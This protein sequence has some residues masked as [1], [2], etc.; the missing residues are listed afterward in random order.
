MKKIILGG[1]AGTAVMTMMMYKVAPMI[2]GK[3]MDIASKLGSM[4][5]DSWALGM[6]A[7]LLNG[8]I[9]FPLIYGLF[10]HKYLPGPNA[11]KG[12]VWGVILWLVAMLV[13]MPVVG[14]GAFM[15]NSGSPKAAM[16]ALMGH[17]VYGLIFGVVSSS[18]INIRKSA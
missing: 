11:I 17:I 9:V 4:L 2:L 14:D 15:L 3:P 7:H 18:A 16:V 10:L 8:I 12:A 1:V 13:V 6:M 5:G